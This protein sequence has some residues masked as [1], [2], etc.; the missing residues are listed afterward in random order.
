M[1]GAGT[2]QP[3]QISESNPVYLGSFEDADDAEVAAKA[4]TLAKSIQKPIADSS[5]DFK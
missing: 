2:P 4:D 3:P 5:P 1:P